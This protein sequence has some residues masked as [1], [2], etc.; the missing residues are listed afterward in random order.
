MRRPAQKG[1]SLFVKEYKKYGGVLEMLLQFP[2]KLP[3]NIKWS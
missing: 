1:H 3:W 2:A